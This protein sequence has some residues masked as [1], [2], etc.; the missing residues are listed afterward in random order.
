MLFKREEFHYDKDED[1]IGAGG[2]G[3]VFRSRLVARDETVA[4]KVLNL[5]RQ[6]NKRH[7]CVCKWSCSPCL[8]AMSVCLSQAGSS[9]R[10]R[11]P[12][13]TGLRC[14]CIDL[15]LTDVCDLNNRLGN[16]C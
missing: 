15:R 14:V 6:L 13:L 4:L 16:Q 1:V 9:L 11:G 12:R 7:V 2:F 3:V 8:S 10:G 5:P